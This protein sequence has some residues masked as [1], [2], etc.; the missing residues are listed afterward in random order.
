MARLDKRRIVRP[1]VVFT[2]VTRL[3]KLR[4]DTALVVRLR[5][6]QSPSARRFRQ[7]RWR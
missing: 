4:I 6:G 3:K 2:P 1:F 7:S 5:P